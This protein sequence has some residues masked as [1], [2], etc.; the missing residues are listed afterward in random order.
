MTEEAFTGAMYEYYEFRGG[1]SQRRP[2][3]EKLRELKIEEDL[4]SRHEESLS[5]VS[6]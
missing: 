1:D 6:Q 2:T 5:S 4:V 3:V